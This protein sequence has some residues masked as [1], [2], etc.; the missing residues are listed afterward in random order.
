MKK[1]I[2][3]LMM[4]L[5]LGALA[6]CGD[7][8]EEFGEPK[9]QGTRAEDIIPANYYWS[10]GKQYA[11]TLSDTESFILFHGSDKEIV[12]SK[13]E[14]FGLTREQIK[15]T[16]Y[17]ILPNSFSIPNDN[18]YQ[19]SDALK[20]TISL[21]YEK[22]KEIDELIYAGPCILRLSEHLSNV[23][24]TNLIYV[25]CNNTIDL[26]QIAQEYNVL[27][28]G[29]LHGLAESVYLIAC[30]NSS[31]GHTIEIANAFFESGLF[32]GAEPSFIAAQVAGGVE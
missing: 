26:E 8:S 6:A 11:I 7:S 21:N 16:P 25:F 1:T 17:G 4:P 31:K 24:M 13:L 19:F 22:A 27:I 2:F 14:N 20:A 3:S 5:M 23:P 29:K 32:K 9:N 12:L 18:L 15:I 28:L 30:T 10:G